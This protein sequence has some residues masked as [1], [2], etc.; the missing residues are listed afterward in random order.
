METIV[1]RKQRIVVGK[2]IEGS[3]KYRR[4]ELWKLGDWKVKKL[5]MK[6]MYYKQLENWKES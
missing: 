1:K 6:I 4:S 5:R 2:L 3:K